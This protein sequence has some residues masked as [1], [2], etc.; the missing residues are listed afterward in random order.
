MASL[1]Q[2]NVEVR[3]DIKLRI[4]QVLQS[5]TNPLYML[6]NLASSGIARPVF[7]WS[8]VLGSNSVS[9]YLVCILRKVSIQ[10]IF[11]L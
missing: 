9:Q 2:A 5:L 6:L 8:T 11:T 7:W 3:A 10:S 1:A 4:L